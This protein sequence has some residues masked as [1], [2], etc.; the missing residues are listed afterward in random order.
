VE[1][2]TLDLATVGALRRR[3]P[4]VDRALTGE[5]ERQE[6]RLL[7]ARC[8]LFAALTDIRQEWIANQLRLRTLIDGEPLCAL[9]APTDGISLVGR[10]A[11]RLV[12]A[13]G[14]PRRILRPGDAVGVLAA[15]RGGRA[16]SAVH[17][18]PVARVYDLE[19][20]AVAELLRDPLARRA[21]EEVAALRRL[22]L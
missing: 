18:A 9:G 12:D 4:A 17:A 1:L 6:A 19:A 11:L 8:R 14:Q 13:A 15:L 3:Y 21:F 2:H 20:D 10:G 16:H 5:A 7:V 22:E